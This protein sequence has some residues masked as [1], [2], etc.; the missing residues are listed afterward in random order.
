MKSFYS[1]GDRKKDAVGAEEEAK[2][3][4]FCMFSLENSAAIAK[5]NETLNQVCE[6]L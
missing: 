2:S 4:L 1:E 6:K 3:D 5:E